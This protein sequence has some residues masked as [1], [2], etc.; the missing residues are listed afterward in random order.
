MKKLNWRVALTLVVLVLGAAYVLPS[1]PAVQN[2]PLARI[3]D[4]KS[5]V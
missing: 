1:I 5:G 4:R 3:L 2:S